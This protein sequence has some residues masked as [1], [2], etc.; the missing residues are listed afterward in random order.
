MVVARARNTKLVDKYIPVF[1]VYTKKIRQHNAIIEELHVHSRG[2]NVEKLAR[3]ADQKRN[4]VYFRSTPYMVMNWKSATKS[5]YRGNRNEL[6][7][8]IN[9]FSYCTIIQKLC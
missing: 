8:N 3:S 6:F 4:N 2:Q 5:S 9:V 1:S 7:A